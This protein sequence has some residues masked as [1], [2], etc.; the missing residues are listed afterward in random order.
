METWMKVRIEVAGRAAKLFVNGS[1]KPVLVVD[2][3]KG[4]DLHGSVGLWSYAGEEAYFSNVHVTQAAPQNLKNGSDIAGSWQLRYSS[5][6]GRLDATMELHR[7]GSKVTG[8]WTSPLGES[9]AVTGSWREGYVELSLAGDWPKEAGIGTPGPVTTLVNG[10]IDGD[11][12]KGRMRV[13]GRS[14][15]V[16]VATRKEQAA[17]RPSN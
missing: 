2:G 17:A 12:G 4:E 3:L 16:W 10:W 13:E 6:A 15:G 14:D 1:E 8:T 11:A 9:K 7:D 5:D